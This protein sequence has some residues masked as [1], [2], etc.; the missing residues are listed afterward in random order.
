MFLHS[1]HHALPPHRFT[2]ADCLT[3]L[4]QAPAATRLRPS[5]L[6]ILRHLLRS[7]M[8]ISTRHFARPDLGTLFEFGAGDLA[9]YFEDAAPKLAADAVAPALAAAGITPSEVDALFVCTCTGYLC[10]GVSSHLAE[11]LGLREDAYLADLVGLGCGAAIPT[12]RAARG[13]L[14]ECPGAR[15]AMVAVEV[16][17]AAFHLDDDRGVLV[18]ACLFGDGASASIWSGA[19][20]DDRPV[21]RLGGFDTVH[22]PALRETIR[23]VNADG[24]LRNQLAPS[25]PD[26]AAAAVAHLWG[27]T[28]QEAV[29]AIVTHGGGRD[30]IEAIEARQPD[31][32]L[33]WTRAVLERTGNLS[34]PSVLL[35]LQ[36]CLEE[37]LPSPG[38]AIWLSSFG[39]GFAAHSARLERLAD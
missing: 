26:D 38:E 1:L 25:V 19:P 33:P 34:S 15:V 10:P 5:S 8:G 32:K 16:C 21:L 24:R 17:S 39:A 31:W 35:A 23:F 6:R 22:R 11:Q 20:P 3:V 28:A 13:F 2:P 18:S 7:N 37:G 14:A 12:L 9:R 29:A 4:D 27:R 30:V 36:D